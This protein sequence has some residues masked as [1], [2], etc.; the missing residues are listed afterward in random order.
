MRSRMTALPRLGGRALDALGAGVDGGH[1]V[2]ER[3]EIIGDE[4]AE[5]AVVVDD[6][7]ARAV[8]GFSRGSHGGKIASEL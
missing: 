3:I 8:D 2:A 6:E 5:L 7:Q 1:V 4:P